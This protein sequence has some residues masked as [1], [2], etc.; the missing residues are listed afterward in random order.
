MM[1]LRDDDAIIEEIEPID[2]ALV[3]GIPAQFFQRNMA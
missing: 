1:T 2:Q 3:K